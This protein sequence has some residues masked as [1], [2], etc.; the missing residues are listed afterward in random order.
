MN[1][2]VLIFNIHI[3]ENKIYMYINILYVMYVARLI[4]LLRM[5]YMFE[6]L[7][8]KTVV[9][10]VEIAMSNRKNVIIITLRDSFG[11]DLYQLRS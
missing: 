1:Y 8:L 10:S 5:I 4:N 9:I 11:F 7:R 6:C 3:C 2:T